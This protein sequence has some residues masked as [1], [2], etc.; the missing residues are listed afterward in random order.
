[1]QGH[2][3]HPP[4]D[5]DTMRSAY[6]IKELDVYRL[7]QLQQPLDIFLSHDWPRGIANH[8]NLQ[9]LLSRK[10]FLRAEVRFTV[11]YHVSGVLMRCTKPV[12]R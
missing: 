9:Q 10:A 5:N 8:G 6:H 3:E 2:H 7:K 12:T 1:M 4:Y 11:G